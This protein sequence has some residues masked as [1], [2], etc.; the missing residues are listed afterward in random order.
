MRFENVCL[1][2]IAVAL[3]EEVWTSA[4][5]EAR[6]QPLYD[7]LRL[8]AGRLELMT[9]IRERR[10]WPAGTRASDA[11]AA[12]GRAVLQKSQLRAA[13]VELFIHAAVSRDMLE[14]AT[15]SFAHRKIGLPGTAQILDVSN[16]CL[17]FLNA[18]TL[19]AGLIESGQI[20]C[21]MIVSGENGRPLLEQTLRTLVE[22][23]LTRNQ[24]KPFFANLT[25]GS[26][27]VAA[28]VCH[29]SLVTGRPHRL[30]GGTARA[31]TQHSDLCQGDNYAA[32]SLV[33][34]TDSEQLL[35]AGVALAQE[36]W[37]DFTTEQGTDFDRFVCHQVG[38]VHRRKLYETLGL[39]LARDYSTF[40]RL[41][42][43]GSA[44]LPSALA[45]AAEAGAVT[46]GMRVGLLGIGSGLNCLMLALEW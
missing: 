14:P 31:A 9:G 13:D 25:I 41:G 26:A 20:R 38:S 21:A 12:A 39:D 36:T 1:E 8:S 11:S 6:L 35:L 34:Q 40:D 2:S 22:Q 27:A 33:M 45:L 46:E 5:I 43:T 3:P 28:I 4:Q 29:K 24:I 18:L 17:G 30:L 42:N 32:E 37:R 19:A 15:A 16:A 23:P 44:A 10:M 7:R